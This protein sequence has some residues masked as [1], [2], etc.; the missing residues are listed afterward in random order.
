ME[1]GFDAVAHGGRYVLVGVVKDPITFLD[2]DFHRKEMTLAGQPQRHPGRFRRVME[3]MRDG[4]VPL[5]RL[6]THRTSW[7][8]RS[9]DLPRWARDKTGLVKALIEI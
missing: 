7:R 1:A 8:P 2:P 9:T 3:A 5:D 4:E 6:V